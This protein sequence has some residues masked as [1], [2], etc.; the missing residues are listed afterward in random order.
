MVT[1]ANKLRIAINECLKNKSPNSATIQEIYTFVENKIS[2]DEEDMIPPNLHGKPVSEPRW[3]RN[4]RNVLKSDSDLGKIFRVSRG[5]Y[6]L[7]YHN[8][9]KTISE[10]EVTPQ[11]T[12]FGLDKAEGCCFTLPKVLNEEIIEFFR[13]REGSLQRETSL[14]I[15]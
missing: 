8:S 3:R 13:L 6:R 11:K 5:Q 1:P 4:V 10:F 7:P 9:N 14:I 15:D 2:F 12:F